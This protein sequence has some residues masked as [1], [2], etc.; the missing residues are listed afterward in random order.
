MLL[1]KKIS[2]NYSLLQWKDNFPCLDSLKPLVEDNCMK[3]TPNNSQQPEITENSQNIFPIK[4]KKTNKIKED[5]TLDWGIL[6]KKDIDRETFVKKIIKYLRSTT[7][8][9]VPTEGL[10]KIFLRNGQN[11]EYYDFNGVNIYSLKMIEKIFMTAPVII[12]KELQRYV[13]LLYR[14]SQT[15]NE[16]LTK[17]YSAI[18]YDRKKKQSGRHKTNIT[19]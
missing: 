2:C 6:F 18:R 19:E 13:L 8:R 7:N 5:V 10:K 4:V 12:E 11:I 3:V 15:I 1:F 14:D 17:N 16:L 9:K